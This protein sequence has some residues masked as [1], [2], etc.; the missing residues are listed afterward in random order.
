MYST[1]DTSLAA[2]LVTEGFP[3][4]SIDYSNPRYSFAFDG[5]V[6]EDVIQEKS[7]LYITGKALVDPAAYNRIFRILTKTVRNREQW[8][9]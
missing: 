3:L 4:T 8:G 6:D 1:S 5:N 7:Q 2:Y 9:Y